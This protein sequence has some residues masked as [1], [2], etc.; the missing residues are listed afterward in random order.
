MEAG[1]NEYDVKK[2]A[3]IIVGATTTDIQTDDEQY[4]RRNHEP[5]NQFPG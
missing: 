2:T 4:R 1:M 5:R 3:L